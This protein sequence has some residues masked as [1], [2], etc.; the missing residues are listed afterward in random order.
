MQLLKVYANQSSFHTI[1]FKKNAPNYIV[2]KQKDKDKKKD[3]QTYNGVGKSLL[4]GII[5]FCLGAKKKKYQT[6]CDK[7]KEWEFFLDFEHQGKRYTCSRKTSD[8]DSIF[9]NGKKKSLKKFNDFM[10]EIFLNVPHNREFLTFRSLIP[11]FIRPSRASYVDCRK[12]SENTYEFQQ[13][14]YNSF[15]M[16]VS[17]SLIQKKRAIKKEIDAIQNFS[18]KIKK[19]SF[20]KEFYVGE[21]DV[22]LTLS[23]LNEKID[24]IE[25]DMK[26]FQVAENYNNIQKEA[27]NLEDEIFKLN[28]RLSLLEQ[29]ME[30]IEKSLKLQPHMESSK[31]EKTYQEASFLFPEKVK[32]SL[33]EADLFYKELVYNRKKRLEE[34]KNVIALDIK[35]TTKKKKNKGEELDRKIKFLGEH[36]ALDM[37]IAL[38]EKQRSLQ[39]ERDKLEDYKKI[40]TGATKKA[41]DL[42][43]KMAELNQES[44]LSIDD[45]RK[46]IEDVQS[47]FRRLAKKFYPDSVVGLSLSPNT[48]NNQIA[49]NLDVKIESDGSDGISNVKIFCYD[50]SILFQGKNHSINFLFH[51]SRLFDG[52]DER[53]KT[54]MFKIIHQLFSEQNSFQ[55]IATV[56]QNQLQEAENNL[57]LEDYQKYIEKNIIHTFTDSDD[58][59]KLL[60]ITVD[61]PWD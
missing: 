53:Q 24:K 35:D 12:P 10:G 52:V 45:R 9:L 54:N 60:G 31:I 13:L 61:I 6:F 20:L 21:R 42:D 26:S 8:A 2:A 33:E 57:S 14:L 38:G 22:E 23:D 16:G 11:F 48:G 18:Q 39:A 40:T 27:D 47:F 25:K 7:L 32:K 59:E 15:L 49:Y 36:K 46:Q 34:Q 41:R 50:L 29:S 17:P 37:F 1:E 43:L 28:N 5:H 55:Y 4:V 58:T 44:S 3:G 30:T 56:N 19:D 51:D